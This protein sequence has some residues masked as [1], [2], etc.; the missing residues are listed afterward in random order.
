M[1]DTGGHPNLLFRTVS[2]RVQAL[3]HGRPGL[4]ASAYRALTDKNDTRCASSF[5]T[6]VCA[7]QV[8]K[9]YDSQFQA[10]ISFIC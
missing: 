5:Q 10:P 2:G 8:Q 6:L 4:R 9:P 7:T 1:R 3:R